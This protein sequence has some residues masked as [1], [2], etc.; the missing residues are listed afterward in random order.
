MKTRF[1][2]SLSVIRSK[3]HIVMWLCDYQSRCFNL[4]ND[5]IPH[6]LQI[7][8]DTAVTLSVFS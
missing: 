4:E 1:P 3:A 5:R 8:F 2:F 6:Q 7:A